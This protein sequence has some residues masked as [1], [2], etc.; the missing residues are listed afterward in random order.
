MKKV[1]ALIIVSSALLSGCSDTE[2][3]SH[4][5][6]ENGGLSYEI[7]SNKPF[8][9]I[10]NEYKDTRLFSRSYFR[11][12]KIYKK[13]TFYKNGQIHVLN[14]TSATDILLTSI[15]D[16]DGKDISDQVNLTLWE[17][18]V[19]KSQG[20]Y[21]SGLRDGVWEEFDINGI[22][23]SRNHWDQGQVLSPV[24]FNLLT[25]RNG[26]P[27]LMK[28]PEPYSGVVEFILTEGYHLE[29]TMLQQFKNGEPQGFQES[30]YENGDLREYWSALKGREFDFNP[31]VFAIKDSE[32]GKSYWLD[33]VYR[34]YYEDAILNMSCE[35]I[36][37]DRIGKYSCKELF[38]NGQVFK[39]SHWSHPLDSSQRYSEGFSDGELLSFYESGKRKSIEYYKM[40]KPVGIWAQFSEEG[41]DISNGEAIGIENT[42]YQPKSGFY[43]NAKQDGQ[44]T[45]D[46]GNFITFVNGIAEGPSLS[47][48][49]DGCLRG[50]GMY[51]NAKKDGE[52]IEWDDYSC[53]KTKKVIYIDG[54][55]Q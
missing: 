29:G 42:S 25:I 4:R 20:K 35:A 44:W 51:K 48:V 43:K 22:S 3:P 15:F 10:A 19:T 47:Y 1:I 9:G 54:V 55:E 50:Q 38:E 53:S 30:Y 12:G 37:L 28:S 26:L 33:G 34:F 23:I 13:E 16:K 40:D 52:W 32:D 8:N 2:V 49:Y 7:G 18:G 21:S 24:K 39:V 45:D 5:L 36:T 31:E 27:Y 46:D 6:I 17:N 41:A 11:V 14:E